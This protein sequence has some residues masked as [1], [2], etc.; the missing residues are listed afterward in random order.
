MLFA[1][2]PDEPL[3][4]LLRAADDDWDPANRDSETGKYQYHV[5][6]DR[7]TAATVAEIIADIDDEPNGSVKVERD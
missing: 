3:G 6:R 2:W 7:R 4:L 5:D 1:N